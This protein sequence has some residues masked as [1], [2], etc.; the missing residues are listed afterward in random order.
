MTIVD[1]LNDEFTKGVD[2]GNAKDSIN[3][4]YTS[5]EKIQFPGDEVKDGVITKD[6]AVKK[7]LRIFID[8]DGEKFKDVTVGKFVG[9]IK[10]VII[11]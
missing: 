6:G 4:V 1:K 11:D 8:K 10:G 5:L 7:I 3:S 9:K 2:L